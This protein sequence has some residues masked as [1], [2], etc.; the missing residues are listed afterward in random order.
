MNT[1]HHKKIESKTDFSE[2]IKS[3]NLI[4]SKLLE[5]HLRPFASGGTNGS[6]CNDVNDETMSDVTITIF[7]TSKI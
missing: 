3:Q 1:E 6:Q 2:V 4:F 7:M 5:C